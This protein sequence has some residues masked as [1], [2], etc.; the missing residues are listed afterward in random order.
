MLKKKY[1]LKNNEIVSIIPMGD[2]H[3]GS[4]QFNEEFFEYWESV[5]SKIKKNRRIYL[6]GDLLESASKKVG[7]SAFSTNMTLDDQKAYLMDILKPLKDD[8]VVYCQGNHENRLNNDY[9]FNIAKDIARELDIEACNQYIDSFKVND[10]DFDIM[11]R[12][13]KGSSSRRDL[14]MGKLEKNTTNIE[15]DLYLEG[16]NHRCMWWN[17]LIRN[18][19]G[20]KRKY[21]GYTGSFLNYEGY[22]D[23]MYLPIEPP[24]F[25]TININQNRIVKSNQYFCDEMT[26]HI[27]FM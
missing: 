14:A 8:I 20:I 26:P 23:S 3:I 9:N 19:D 21:Y 24:A 2:A 27:K 16:H 22:V 4:Y 17:S 18:K 1:K 10:F 5:V 7:D 13:G 25:M 6:M 15:A 12:H 11:V